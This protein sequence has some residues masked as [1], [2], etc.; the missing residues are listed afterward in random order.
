MANSKR[1][2]CSICGQP[3]K[4]MFGAVSLNRAPVVCRR[5]FGHQTYDGPSQWTYSGAAAPEEPVPQSS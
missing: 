5:C 4:T 2:K 1:I 3:I